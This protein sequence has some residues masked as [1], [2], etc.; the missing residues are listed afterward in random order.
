M[1][2][3]I[4]NRRTAVYGIFILRCLASSMV[5]TGCLERM[6]RAGPGSIIDADSFEVTPEI[7]P[8]LG[9]LTEPGEAI[10]SVKFTLKGIDYLEP[11]ADL[12]MAARFRIRWK[13]ENRMTTAIWLAYGML[14]ILD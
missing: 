13:V 7:R 10:Q 2:F 4:F 12:N 9:P 5:V 3:D 8:G 1:R 14:V 6:P 11:S